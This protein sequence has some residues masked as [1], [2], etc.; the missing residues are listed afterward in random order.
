M[1]EV[2]EKRCQLC[3]AKYQPK[4]M[5]Y[6]QKYCSSDCRDKSY[7]SQSN[8]ISRRQQ[9]M[10]C[11]VV[12]EL[13][14]G[15]SQQKY[16]SK[17]CRDKSYKSQSNRM[18]K[19]QQCM[20]C[21]TIFELAAG[22]SH[23][24]YCNRDC[25]DRSY[26]FQSNG[27]PQLTQEQLEGK[28]CCT[29]GL[30]I[31]QNNDKSKMFC[32]LNCEQKFRCCTSPDER[33]ALHQKMRAA[34]RPGFAIKGHVKLTQEQLE[35]RQCLNCG[36]GISQNKKRNNRLF[37][38]QR[39]GAQFRYNT[40][41]QEKEKTKQQLRE[42]RNTWATYVCKCC[43]IEFEDLKIRRRLYCSRA[44]SNASHGYIINKKQ[45]ETDEVYLSPHYGMRCDAI[46]M[47]SAGMSVAEIAEAIDCYPSMV[48]AWLI[49]YERRQNEIL[50]HRPFSDP[51]FRYMRARNS[52]EWIAILN[53]EMHR[54]PNFTDT[55]IEVAVVLCCGIVHAKSGLF[56]LTARV[57]ELGLEPTNGNVYAFCGTG[58]ETL[59]YF[60][61]DGSG[62]QFTSRLRS[63]GTYVWPSEK[64][65]KTLVIT[66]REFEFILYGSQQKINLENP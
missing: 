66:Y 1:A 50:D 22:V 23:Q 51:F 45:V 20:F 16:C 24:K 56:A 42:M 6:R 47:R 55:Q 14:A 25:R 59:V 44:C 39:C 29:C 2:Q 41:P 7:K 12:F 48:R 53:D 19:Q 57:E 40:T 17:Q 28:N 10:F 8:G 4:N 36:A 34:R 46:K 26:I 9:C 65:G 61:W 60:R 58:R 33:A 3:G 21:G 30:A 13:A 35:G 38:S 15:V 63:Y 37:C 64:V 62:F 27:I 54:T 11:G 52:V 43:G 18:P 31:E 49:P 5:A 32:C